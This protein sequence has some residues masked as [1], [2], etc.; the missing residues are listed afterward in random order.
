MS[1]SNSDSA[2]L[3]SFDDGWQR[4]AATVQIGYVL[5]RSW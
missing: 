3:V 1:P 2:Q 4:F 5:S